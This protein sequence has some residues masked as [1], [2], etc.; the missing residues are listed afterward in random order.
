MILD[1]GV[2]DNKQKTISRLLKKKV[3][4]TVAG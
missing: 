2:E 3:G 1:D 4:F